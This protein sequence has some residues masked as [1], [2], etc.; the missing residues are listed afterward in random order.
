MG[1][2]AKGKA[3][4]ILNPAEPPMIMRDTVFTLSSGGSEEAIETGSGKGARPKRSRP[5]GDAI[6]AIAKAAASAAPLT[7]Q[8]HQGD[9]A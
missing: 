4:I 3:I 5:P 1:G 7:P 9:F 2:A 6:M 8:V